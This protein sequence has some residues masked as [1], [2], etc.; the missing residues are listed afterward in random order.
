EDP[1]CFFEPE[2]PRDRSPHEE[3]INGNTRAFIRFVA[4]T[5]PWRDV[6]AGRLREKI[7]ASLL[8]SAIR[9]RDTLSS[10]SAKR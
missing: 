9:I 5:R 4:S 6:F 2:T 7:G 1:T 10:S 3:E 8:R